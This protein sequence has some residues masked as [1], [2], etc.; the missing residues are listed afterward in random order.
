MVP[1]DSGMVREARC[2]W[3]GLRRAALAIPAAV[4]ILAGSVPLAGTQGREGSPEWAQ[5]TVE[6]GTITLPTSVEG[7]PDVNPPFDQFATRLAYPYTLRQQILDRREPRTWRTLVLENEFL[8]CT[9]LPDLGGHL[10]TCIDKVNGESLF[11][12]NP[13]IKLANIAY[14]GAWAALGVEFNFPVSHSWVTISPVDFETVRHPDGSASI[15]VGDVDRVYGGQWRVEL[16]LRPGRAV[17]EQHTTLY[18]RSERRHRFYWWTNAAVQVHDDSRLW[19]PQTLTASHGFTEVDTWPV[20][21]RGVDLSVVGNH[22]HGTVSLFSHGS[23]EPFMGVYHPRT[24]SGVAHYSSPVDLPAKKVWSWGSDA[25]GLD[26]RKALSDNESAYVEIQA[27]LFRNQETYA[28]LEPQE[29]IR[30][31]EYWMPI[32]GI[33]GI[34]R[35]TPDA[36]LH[37]A[38]DE[39]ANAVR[40]G[41]QAL[42]AVPDARIRIACGEKTLTDTSRALDP[43]TPWQQA[44]DNAPR[45]PCRVDVEEGAGRSLLSHVEGKYDVIPVEEVTLGPQKNRVPPPVDARTEG[46]WLEAG[47]RQ[48]LEGQRLAARETYAAGLKKFPESAGLQKASGRLAV[49]L[50]RHHEAIPLLESAL[51][52]ETT[53]PE[54]HYYLGLAR[55]A[56][57]DRRTAKDHFARAQQFVAF[58][59][60]ARFALAKL[61]AQAGRLDEAL[62]LVT[63][64]LEA[65]PEATRLGAAEVILL[66]RLGREADARA[67][68]QAWI[69]ADPL[70]ATLRHERVRVEGADGSDLWR[71]LAA[72]A[73]DV[74]GLAYDYMALGLH[75]EALGILERR[76]PE[77]G[78]VAEPGV[79]H[80]NAHP[81]IAYYRGYCRKQM[82]ASPAADYDE[83]AGRTTT[84]VFPNR[85]DTR[86]VLEDVLRDRPDDTT[87]RFLLGSMYMAVGE[88]ERAVEAWE[89]VRRVRPN[90]P[91]LHRNLGLAL[92][93]GLDDVAKAAAVM[94]EGL[95]H[96]PKN[97]ALYLGLDQALSL[98][99]VPPATRVR[100]LERYPADSRPPELVIALAMALTEAGRFDE[101]EGLFRNRFFP[102]EELGTNVRQVYMQVRVR[103]ARDAAASGRCADALAIIDRLTDPV[104]GVSFTSD[105]ME[106]FA[107]QTRMEYEVGR[108]AKTCGDADRATRHLKAAASR[109]GGSPLDLAFAHRAAAVLGEAGALRPRLEQALEDARRRAEAAGT[110]MPGTLALGRGLLLVELGRPEEARAHFLQTLRLP[111]RYLAHHLARTELAALGAASAQRGRTVAPAVQ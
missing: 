99:G 27:G 83:A 65:A 103:R 41:I 40:V 13:S 25:D 23:R 7:P 33:G 76:Y 71:Q 42:R 67:R 68:L 110:N 32:R 45:D 102:R 38:R 81:L 57:G 93:H 56:T 60:P 64:A 97:L 20:N 26:W 3:G 107:R 108:I 29:S 111:D 84:Y 96:D 53:D 58:R 18:N 79:P 98:Q 12:A 21:R 35:V 22:T 28:F 94:E 39:K 78:V 30:F 31:S 69:A 95:A 49:I 6:R 43:R 66:R 10:Y 37:L 74:L 52:R 104:P 46:D 9:V 34:T 15:W 80:P 48:E 2:R 8:K 54:L 50:G 85:P 77:E 109:R 14:R 61:A 1:A 5:V 4:A 87:A 62:T 82:G 47:T 88:I 72:N 105:G 51:A 19:Y 24:Q 11:Y 44:F 59:A 100:A 63:A 106:P 89:A 70:N 86:F 92:L 36:V 75:D 55:V 101:A 90:L 17:L 91:V 73:D 16:R